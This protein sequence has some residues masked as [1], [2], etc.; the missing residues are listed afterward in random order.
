MAKLN[1]QTGITIY[2]TDYCPYCHAAKA[3]LRSRGLEYN[4]IDVAQD[5]AKRQEMMERSGRRT[6]PQVFFGDNHIGGNDDL[7]T[8]VRNVVDVAEVEKAAA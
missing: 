8:Y 4:E 2:T 3:L 7:Q 1:N 6:V 5:Q